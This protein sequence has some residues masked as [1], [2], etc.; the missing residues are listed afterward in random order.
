M[1][2]QTKSMV[3]SRIDGLRERY[4][5]DL[6]IMGH[7]YQSDDI[8]AHCDIT[9]D[10]LELARCIRDIRAK[11]IV[12]CG[13][14]FMGE[15]AAL[16]AQKNQGVYLPDP[17]SECM[18][19]MMARAETLGLVLDHLH[20]N[21]RKVIP[22]A[23][24]NSSLAIKM[25]VGKFGGAVCTSANAKKVLAWALETG[26]GVLFV[27][28]RNLGRNTARQLGLGESD[29]HIL[30]INNSG[31]ADLGIQPLDRKILLWPGCCAVHAKM[32]KD[33]VSQAR[34]KYP[35][36]R[37]IVHPECDPEVI[38]TCDAAGSTSFIIG[39]AERLARSGQRSTL[40]I[41]T[42]NN[43]V[44]RLAARYR[45]KYPIQPLTSA[46]CRN[47]AQTDEQ[48]LLDTLI[49]IGK[50]SAVPV[51]I[52]ETMRENATATLTRMLNICN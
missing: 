19:A 20:G 30:Q 3:K 44:C 39:E 24:V 50:Q 31:L 36:C 9:G 11:H 10:S 47:M 48:K 32:T 17:R 15:S 45:D 18:M 21:G 41:G 27:P 34:A 38:D 4:G 14:F 26:D 22:V 7:H 25:V 52:C 28:D 23:Y 42:E 37:I 35:G 43:L 33:H 2:R 5:S 1:D 13:V 46:L 29:W 16:L 51:T 8:V 49:G 12:F 6:C 40:V